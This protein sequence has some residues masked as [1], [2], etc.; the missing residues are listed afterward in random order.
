MLWY[1]YNMSKHNR[2]GGD[3]KCAATTR[4]NMSTNMST[5]KRLILMMVMNISI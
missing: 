3:K 5:R 2:E 1:N 4:I